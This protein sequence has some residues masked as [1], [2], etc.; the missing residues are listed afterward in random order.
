[1]TVAD[2]QF[3]NE[4]FTITT[5]K[6]REIDETCPNLKR[7]MQKMGGMVEIQEANKKFMDILTKYNLV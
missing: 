1:M 7:W 3:Y 5:L 4:I 6:K 2:I